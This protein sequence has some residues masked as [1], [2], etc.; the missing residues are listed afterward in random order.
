MTTTINL[1]PGAQIYYKKEDAEAVNPGKG[2][3]LSSSGPDIHGRMKWYW[4]KD[5]ISYDQIILERLE[6]LEKQVE[7]LL[8]KGSPLG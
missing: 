2:W 8:K 4:Q 3:S 1:G 7:L 6:K 5:L